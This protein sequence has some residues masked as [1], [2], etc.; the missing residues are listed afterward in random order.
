[1]TA[2]RD[3]LLQRTIADWDGRKTRWQR[4][5][6][7][8]QSQPEVIDLMARIELDRQDV[9]KAVRLVA[10]GPVDDPL[11]ARLRGRLALARRDAK[12][13]V[14]HFRIALADDPLA[15]ETLFGLT[16][17]LQLAGDPKAAEPYGQVAASLDRLNSLVQR[18][19]AS[20]AKKDGSLMRRVWSSMRGEAPSE[21]AIELSRAAWYRQLAIR[22]RNPTVISESQRALYR[23]SNP[24]KLV[25]TVSVHSVNQLLVQSLHLLEI[26][27]GRQ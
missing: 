2:G 26:T 22:R 13:A 18:A 1:M 25:P 12:S 3:W 17:A 16:A 19:L 9:D 5:L 23:L 11:L 24:M 14:R 6:S 4:F 20:G 21:L 15:R 27:S 8:P 7:L 10:T